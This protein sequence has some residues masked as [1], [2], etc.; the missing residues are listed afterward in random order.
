MLSEASDEANTQ[1]LTL[2]ARP[3]MAGYIGADSSEQSADSRLQALRV[4]GGLNGIDLNSS[5]LFEDGV[6][7]DLVACYTIDPILPLDIVPELNFSNRAYVRGMSGENSFQRKESENKKNKS[8]WDM[9]SDVKRGTEIQK[10][11][12]VRNL[13]DKFFVFSAFD[14]VSGKATAEQSIDLREKRISQSAE[15]KVRLTGSAAK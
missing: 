7:I 10:Q 1:L 5:S 3:M 9:E 6:T 13:P 14:S 4:V 11:Q 12:N 2:V 15:L 8:V